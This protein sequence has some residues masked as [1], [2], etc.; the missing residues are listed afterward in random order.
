MLTLWAKKIVMKFFVG[1]GVCLVLLFLGCYSG[2]PFVLNFLLV[3]TIG[4][5]D[6]LSG[7]SF[8]RNHIPSLPCKRFV[9]SLTPKASVSMLLFLIVECIGHILLYDV[10]G[11]VI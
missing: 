11:C 1:Y 4:H 8:L 3:N 6:A 9:P 5:R 2:F 10:F 7:V